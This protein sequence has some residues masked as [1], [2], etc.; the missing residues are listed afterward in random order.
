MPTFYSTARVRQS[1][2]G[3]QLSSFERLMK[4]HSISYQHHEL[5]D[6]S[7]P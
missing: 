3:E 4:K 7:L 6:S 5:P 1:P 2:P